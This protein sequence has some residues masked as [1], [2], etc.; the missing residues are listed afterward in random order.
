MGFAK[1]DA[2]I[3]EQRI[4]PVCRWLCRD[5]L[6]AGMGEFIR[7]AN[8]KA[9][10]RE[11][12]IEC[13]CKLRFWVEPILGRGQ[14][15]RY[16]FKFYKQGLSILADDLVL[17]WFRGA[18][19]TKIDAA[20]GWGLGLP[21]C[22]QLGAISGIDPVAVEAGRQM[23]GDFVAIRSDESHLTQPGAIFDIAYFGLE[24]FENAAPLGGDLH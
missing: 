3:Q 12:G 11:A 5:T 22:V 21:Q 19:D 6:G 18:A 20:Y 7:F 23:Y 4:E 9:V 17:G 13:R 10:E 15:G 1:A 8:N 24:S 16:G 14:G 2:A